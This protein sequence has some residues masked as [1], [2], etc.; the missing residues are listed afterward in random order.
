M[1]FERENDFFQFVES[2][3]PSS[4]ILS[5]IY[6]YNTKNEEEQKNIASEDDAMDSKGRLSLEKEEEE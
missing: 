1:I 4:F 3:S 6:V 5:L 2:T